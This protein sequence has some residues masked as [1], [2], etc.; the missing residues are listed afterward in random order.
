MDRHT[1]SSSDVSTAERLLRW[2]NSCG[3]GSRHECLPV[4]ASG[5][6]DLPEA[7]R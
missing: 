7:F 3:T 5:K 4:A 6:R 1:G 2:V